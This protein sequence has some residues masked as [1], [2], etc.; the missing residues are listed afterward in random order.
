MF[1]GDLGYVCITVIQLYSNAHMWKIRTLRQGEKVIRIL[2]N[3][4][5]D[6]M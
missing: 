6:S 1:V 4:N 3:Q 2:K 5:P